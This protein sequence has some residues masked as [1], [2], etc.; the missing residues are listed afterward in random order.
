M[1]V[2]L[3]GGGVSTNRWIGYTK[4]ASNMPGS[5]AELMARWPNPD[6][7]LRESDVRALNPWRQSIIEASQAPSDPLP[8]N[9]WLVVLTTEEYPL[10]LAEC[11]DA[12]ACLFGLGDPACF[13]RP[14]IAIVGSRR[15]SLDGL[16]L[17][18]RFGYELAQAGFVIVS[19]LAHGVDTAAHKGAIAAGGKTIAVMATGIDAIYPSVNRSL[20]AEIE[21]S[22][23]LVTEFLPGSAPK[24]HHF[25]RRNR[26][27]SGLSIATVVIEAGVPS[28]TLITA[29]AAAEQGRDVYA[30]PWSISHTQGEGC[31][32]LLLEGALIATD[33]HD[34]ID[35]S[36]WSLPI[37]EAGLLQNYWE[38]KG[39]SYST[40][41]FACLP[42]SKESFRS[43]PL[44]P[45][46][47]SGKALVRLSDV[48]PNLTSEQA[49]L[50]A[51]I[52]DGHH[53]AEALADALGMSISAVH[54]VLTGLE[55]SGFLARDRDGY[56]KS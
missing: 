22:G 6:A 39:L 45:N 49:D 56:C 1:P 21:K 34:V 29:T 55:I 38:S 18:E 17:A 41:G 12:P 20:S 47:P 43:Q 26:T 40:A 24:K 5:R 53:S 51:F 19:G 11:D 3:G 44:A 16:K 33:P 9:A 4:Y 42:A 35:G 36:C 10:I 50:M 37:S 27:I 25:R 32:K 28:G 7:V 23:V 48:P 13:K 8:E 30:L 15:P 31:L 2:M 14:A 54:R 52:G 46:S